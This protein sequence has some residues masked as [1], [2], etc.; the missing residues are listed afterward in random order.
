[1]ILVIGGPPGSGKTTVAERWAATHGYTLISAGTKFRAMAKA[2]GMTLEAFGRMAEKDPSIDQALDREIL[3]EIRA[4]QAAGAKVVVDGRIQAHLLAREGIP[5]LRVL[6][7]APLEVRAR[8]IARRESKPVADAKREIVAREESERI[9]YK[10]IYGID[11]RDTS[12]FDFVIDSGEKKP[13]EI[14]ATIAARVRG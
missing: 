5:S 1:M 2:R 6:I 3:D 14:V 7:D 13:D 8:R 11:L 12:V 4:K 9:R 10:Q